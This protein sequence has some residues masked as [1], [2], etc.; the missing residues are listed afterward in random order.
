MQPSATTARRL[1]T[2]ALPLTLLLASAPTAQA[3]EPV[4]VRHLVVL[5]DGLNAETVAAELLGPLDLVA[6]TTW[7]H[8]LDGFSVTAPAGSLTSLDDD[9]RVTSVEQ[10]ITVSTTAQSTPTGVARIDTHLQP[11]AGIGTGNLVDVDVAVIDTGIDDHADLNLV[12]HFDCVS[13]LFSSGCK[14]GGADGHG[15]GTHVAGTIGA[16]DNGIN[17]VGV[18]PGARMHGYKVLNDILGSGSSADI[19]DAIDH[20]TG[21]GDIEVIN[22]SLG[23]SGS[24]SATNAA[25]AGATNAGVVVVVAAGNDTANASGYTPAN[26]PN[27]ITVSAITDTD[28]APGGNGGS[29]SGADDSLASYSNY[30]D[31]I[32]IAAPGSCITSL[33]PGGGTTSMSGTSMAS[34]HVAGAAALYV[35]A[36][37]TANSA[38]RW[39]EVLTGLTTTW[40]TPQD[41]P[42]GYATTRNADPLLHLTGC[43][44]AGNPPSNTAPTATVTAPADGTQIELGDAA[45][46]TGQADDAEDGDLSPTIVWTSSLDGSLGSGASVTATLSEGQHLVT[47]SVTDANGA[48]ATDTVTVTVVDGTPP[49]PPADDVVSVVD[50]SWA[51]GTY[52]FGGGRWADVTLELDDQDG[53]AVRGAISVT[54]LV[55]GQEYATHT[56]T[57][58]SS[59]TITFANDQ[60][61][62]GEFSAVVTDVTASGFDWDGQT[63]TNTHQVGGS[64]GWLFG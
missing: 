40:G 3:A 13:A 60:V 6:D 30:G 48:T 1:L 52:V 2:A 15:H 50:V 51:D 34:P 32:D 46:F 59:G 16:L 22:M 62:N 58:N 25:I 63:P 43:G 11:A 20:V 24:S 14:A 54:I 57:T 42:C 38:N 27:A 5:A 7:Q 36:F 64:S 29:C 55:D 23:G 8:A 49:P 9:T 39:T 12:S 53:N 17:V 31:I 56:G 35:A 10:A 33:K 26:S 28:G 37:G 21:R 44:D 19:I 61:P 47:A 45:T 4:L 18:A 41:G